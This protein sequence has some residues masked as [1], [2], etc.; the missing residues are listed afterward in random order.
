MRPGARA[1]ETAASST[2]T[3]ATCP[4]C[5]TRFGDEGALAV[6]RAGDRIVPG[7]RDFCERHRAEVW[8]REGGML[9]VSAAPAQDAR[10]RG[11]G[12][13]RAVSSACPTRP[14]SLSAEEPWPSESSSPR[15]RKGAFMRDGATVQPARLVRALR[16]AVA[17]LCSQ[18]H[19]HSRVTTIDDGR[20]ETA[21][22][23]VRARDDR[24]RHRTR[25]RRAGSRS[26]AA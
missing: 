11:G 8:L 15:F 18:L 21:R 13:G 22:G 17:R 14:F 24:R 25:R 2:A 20:V 3:G 10:G 26:P 6:T 12:R 19:E 4:G 7:I 23:R 5:A 1:G 16:R 9:R